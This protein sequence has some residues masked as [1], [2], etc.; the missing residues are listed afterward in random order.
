MPMRPETKIYFARCKRQSRLKTNRTMRLR[1]AEDCL[2]QT[3]PPRRKPPPR[4]PPVPR[5][6]KRE[7]KNRQ[8]HHVVRAQCYK[9]VTLPTPAKILRQKNE[10]CAK[11]MPATAATQYKIV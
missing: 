6:G 5:N 11:R 4:L 1:C 9:S 3:V 10:C 2:W 8:P 7:N